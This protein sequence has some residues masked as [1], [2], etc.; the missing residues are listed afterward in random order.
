MAFDEIGLL[1]DGLSIFVKGHFL[2]HLK[3]EVTLQN[4]ISLKTGKT[5]LVS[6]DVRTDFQGFSK[7]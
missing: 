5:L 3:S 7:L 1:S 4:I 6:H 2:V